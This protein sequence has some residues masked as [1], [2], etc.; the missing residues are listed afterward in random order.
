VAVKKQS[1]EYYMDLAIKQALKG[2]YYTSPNPC[3]GAVIVK[4]NQII[5]KSYHKQYGQAHA[6]RNAIDD[7]LKKGYKLKGAD[8]YVTLEPCNH[9]GN[10]PPCSDALIS[11]G[12]KRVFYA[13]RD[14]N[15]TAFGGVQKL[16]KA[17]IK[18]VGDILNEQAQALNQ[19]FITNI[20]KKRPYIIAKWA[21]G[22]DGHIATKTGNSAW[23]SSSESRKIVHNMRAIVDGILIGSGTAKKDKPSLTVRDAKGNNPLRIILDSQLTLP[24]NAKVLNDNLAKTLVFCSVSGF[25]NVKKYSSSSNVEFI[26]VATKAGK[27]S[28]DAV[29]S[30]LYKRNI[31]SILIEGGSEVH[32][33]F[34][35]AN[36]VD[37]VFTFVAPVLMGG[38]SAVSAVAG[39][40]VRSVQEGLR[41]QN[42]QFW[43]IDDDILLRG[44]NG[45]HP[46]WSAL[47]F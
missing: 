14:P 12:I 16:K 15:P 41:L 33:S 45:S 5:A 3:V 31:N 46:L 34:F 25:K 22:L 39:K 28:L 6:E 13:M 47:D 19:P 40:G 20:V 44:T 4:N 27:L 17:G 23:I 10:Q 43:Q 2:R 24:K 30:C 42:M 8:I 9:H 26:S 21:M 1:P 37:E 29:L 35:D 36:L 18:C 11:A 7:A 38:S 32:G